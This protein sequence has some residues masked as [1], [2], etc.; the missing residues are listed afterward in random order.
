[1]K[2]ILPTPEQLSAWARLLLPK[3]DI[4]Y[5]KEPI[6]TNEKVQ[7]FSVKE[8]FAN[9]KFQD[10]EIIN[11]LEA[12]KRSKEVNFVAVA[13]PEWFSSL[14]IQEKK[15]LITLQVQLKRGLVLPLPFG[16]LSFPDECISLDHAVLTAEIWQNFPQEKVLLGLAQD[17]DDG[18][19]LEIPPN[20][21]QYIKAFA[22]KYAY[23]S[24]A[25]CLATSIYAITG[26]EEII[27]QW[28]HQEEFLAKLASNNYEETSKTAH[29]KGDI[30]VGKNS[31]GAI[32]HAAY[33]LEEDCFFNK[34]G[35]Y[36]FNPWKLISWQTL[37]EEWEDLSWIVYSQK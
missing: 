24:G 16:N 35:Q 9:P 7:I 23:K 27:H 28:L 33:C 4:F 31:N 21:P 36:F 17:W 14:S 15:S 29:E 1:M 12:W 25:N 22:N 34:D 11:A 3:D 37:Q 26:E 6:P 13:K 2:K 19:C 18:L 20:A 32:A 8:F 10:I 30:L 5:L